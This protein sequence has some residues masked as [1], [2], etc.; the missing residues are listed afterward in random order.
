M[1]PNHGEKNAKYK[2]KHNKIQIIK[3]ALPLN[4]NNVQ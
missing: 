3:M 4:D 1:Q 2:I